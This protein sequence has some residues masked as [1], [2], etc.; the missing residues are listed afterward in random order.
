MS[1][2][3][4]TWLILAIVGAIVPLAHF[5]G[6]FAVTGGTLPGL[7]GAWFENGAVAGLAW[8]MMISSTALSIFMVYESVVKQDYWPLFCLL[9]ILA[10]GLA[11]ALPLYL[12]LRSRP[13][14]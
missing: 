1:R 6:W 12:F 9:A 8:D 10:V 5:L 4:L 7:L 2:L 13:V 3:R 14:R 11:C